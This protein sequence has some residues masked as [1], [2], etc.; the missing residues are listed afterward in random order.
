MNEL[1]DVK[2]L[3]EAGYKMNPYVGW[4]TR[5]VGG[6][7]AEILPMPDRVQVTVYD[8]RERKDDIIAMTLAIAI[9]DGEKW[10]ETGDAE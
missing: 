3:V 2:T 6:R 7:R 1:E 4:W 8:G 5:K 9:E 10:L